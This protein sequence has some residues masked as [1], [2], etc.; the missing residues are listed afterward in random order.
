[1]ALDTRAQV[2]KCA[3]HSVIVKVQLSYVY[4]VWLP[5]GKKEFWF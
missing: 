5:D 4:L 3:R 2:S 1:M